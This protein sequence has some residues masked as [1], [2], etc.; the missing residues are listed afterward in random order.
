MSDERE[1]IAGRTLAEE[2]HCPKCGHTL[3]IKAI[4]SSVMTA[5]GRR[6]G[7]L[8]GKRR[9]ETLSQ[10][11][12]SSIALRAAKIRWGHKSVTKGKP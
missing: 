5:Q 11:E 4:I 1:R 8:G 3:D 7:K 10:E 12:R 9:M 2:L 6:G